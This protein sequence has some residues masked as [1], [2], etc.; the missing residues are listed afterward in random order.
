[1][2]PRGLPR[3]VLILFAHTREDTLPKL[4]P[5][6]FLWKKESLCENAYEKQNIVLH[7]KITCL[8]SQKSGVMN[9]GMIFII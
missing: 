1:M 6:A 2:I 8:T 5:W 4:L 9:F 3:E 7:F